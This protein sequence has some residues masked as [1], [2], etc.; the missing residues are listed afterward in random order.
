[1]SVS[2]SENVSVVGGVVIPGVLFVLTMVLSVLLSLLP[3][4]GVSSLSF[5]NFLYTPGSYN[6]WLILFLFPIWILSYLFLIITWSN[7]SYLLNS[8]TVGWTAVG[9]SSVIILAIGYSITFLSPSESSAYIT[10]DGTR[11]TNFTVQMGWTLLLLIFLG[12]CGIT[13]YL[14]HLK[15]N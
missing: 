1:M 2:S 5:L 15:E 4:D 14:S 12:I 7:F 3:R 13:Y 10:E 11:L 9:L 6:I 8:R